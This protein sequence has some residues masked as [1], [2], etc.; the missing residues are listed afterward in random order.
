VIH[1][2]LFVAFLQMV[3][4]GRGEATIFKIKPGQK[5]NR[6]SG[7]CANWKVYLLPYWQKRTN[8]NYSLWM[9]QRANKV[10]Q[11]INTG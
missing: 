5:E 8:T 3:S 7:L 9:R 1:S 6:K 2:S 11:A 10:R 4:P